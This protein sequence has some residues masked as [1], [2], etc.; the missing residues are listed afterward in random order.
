MFAWSIIHAI[1]FKKDDLIIVSSD[2][3][4]YLEIAERFNAV[5]FLRSKNLSKETKTTS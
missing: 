1:L 4:E 3:E 5:P 2:S